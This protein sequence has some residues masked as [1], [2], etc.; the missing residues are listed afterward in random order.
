MKTIGIIGGGQLGQ[1][2]AISAIYAGHQ[3]IVLDPDASCPASHVAEQIV[4][5]YDDTAAIAKLAA[6]ADVLTYEFENV[7]AD[8]LAPYEDKI[9]QGLDLLRIS[10]NRIFE[11]DFLT[12]AGIKVAPYQ[13][14]QTLRDL[15]DTD[16][17]KKYVLKTATGGYDGHGQ[18]VIQSVEDWEMGR[19]LADITPCVLEEF[20]DYFKEISVIISGN[21][22]DFSVFP[23]CENLHRH[24]I[25]DKTIMPARISKYLAEE[26]CDMALKIAQSLKLSGTLCVEMFVTQHDILVNEIAPRPHNSG[27]ATIEACDFSQFDLHIRGILGEALP[28]VALLS[29]AV[30]LQVLGQDMSAARHFAQENP[31]AHLHLYGK[32]EAKENRKMGHV[33]VLTDDAD[34][35]F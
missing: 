10:Q 5:R 21:G 29:P 35:T 26:A 28:K 22:Q 31:S 13:V 3:V 34:M 15:D 25:L 1:M 11:K 20:V 23:V 17:T 18:V 16:L 9:P 19:D 24:N 12:K 6:R 8:A 4:A 30:M 14:I 32:I 33:T 27:H 2:M 7:S